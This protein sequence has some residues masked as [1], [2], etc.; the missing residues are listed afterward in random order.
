MVAA[1]CYEQH[2]EYFVYRNQQRYASHPMVAHTRW[3]QTEY[4]AMRRLSN[5]QR[6]VTAHG[7]RAVG[8][9]AAWG[10]HAGPYLKVPGEY[11]PSRGQL[12]PGGWGPLASRKALCMVPV[13]QDRVG[14]LHP[15]SGGI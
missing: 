11:N 7:G 9:R 12:I 15:R 3:W 8:P 13:G 10:I 6:A 1:F 2:V 5:T 4:I 14:T